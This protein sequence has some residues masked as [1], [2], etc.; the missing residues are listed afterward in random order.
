MSVTDFIIQLM[1]AII[2]GI[3]AL[4]GVVVTV[5]F[6]RSAERLSKDRMMKELFTEFN[7]RYDQLNDHLMFLEK[8]NLTLLE[9]DEN[10]K[11]KAKVIDFFNLCA[12]EFYWY[13]KG[14][15]DPKVWRAWSSG[16]NYWVNEVDAIR[17]LWLRELAANGKTSYY[18]DENEEFF[19]VLHSS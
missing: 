10:L 9:L 2:T 17:D 18:L 7:Q 14:R 4:A 13:K 12:E 1:P 6:Q 19:Q 11:C 15:I 16:M 8:K 3:V 5:I